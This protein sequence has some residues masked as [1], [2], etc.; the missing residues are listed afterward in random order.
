MLINFNVMIEVI[1]LIENRFLLTEDSVGRKLLKG[2]I[3]V[4]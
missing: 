4:G 2:A 1:N 3:S